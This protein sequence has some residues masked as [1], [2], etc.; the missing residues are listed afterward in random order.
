METLRMIC[1][2]TWA[3]F[4]E[5]VRRLSFLIVLAIT[6][7]AGYLFVPP[8]DAGYRVLQLGVYRGI[9]N[10]AW[11][12][13]MFGLIAALHLP[14]VGFF[15]VKNAVEH[16]RRTGVGEIIATSPISKL[17]YVA[18]KWLSNLAVLVLILSVMTVMA[19]AMQI[20][21]AEDTTLNLWALVAPI[22]MMGLPVLA[23]AAALAILFE[24][25]SFLRGSLG[26]V[27][28]FFLWLFA[29]A[30]V[31]SGAINDETGLAQRKNDLYGYTNQLVDIQGQ[32]LSIDP[33]AEVGSSLINVGRDVEHT[34]VWD[35]IQWQVTT[36]LERA[37]WAGLAVVLAL[38]A[39]IPFDRF[40]PAPVHVRRVSRPGFL[41]LAFVVALTLFIPDLPVFE[42]VCWINVALILFVVAFLPDRY[43]KA[44]RKLVGLKDK[45][46]LIAENG[47]QARQEE[48]SLTP[49]LMP[50]QN[51]AMNRLGEGVPSDVLT[52]ST[53]A[54]QNEG[55]LNRSSQIKPVEGMDIPAVISSILARLSVLPF[56]EKISA[57]RDAPAGRLYTIILAEC[58]LMLRGHHRIWWVGIVG[59]N[60]TC[61]VS[62]EE[63]VRRFLFPSLWAW[64]VFLWSQMGVRESRFNT[65]GMTFS[66]PRPVWRQL[67]AVWSA[68]VILT[69]ILGMGGWIRLL[70]TGEIIRLFAWFVGTL[71]VPSLALAMGVWTRHNRIF[72][73]IYL[74]LWYVGLI[75][76]V[77]IFDFIGITTESITRG[78]PWVYFGIAILLLGV[79]LAGRVRQLNI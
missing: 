50:F 14:L 24:S 73:F 38:A 70:L 32:V 56:L 55:Q 19:G 27:V 35:G 59:L 77:P 57:R 45:D 6:V 17:V 42:R 54:Y 48:S 65:E 43:M 25:V 74:L 75:E 20:I 76:Q 4:L 61:L 3:D 30:I 5:R 13:L 64:P 37:V 31:L 28:I 62:P 46:T 71:F 72:E 21:R 68:G 34:F 79:A 60:I 2:L 22:W 67:P 15:L 53:I 26:N 63:I 51:D 49:D 66:S 8:E 58:R 7:G 16:D 47:L 69:L 78:S 39:S 36:I 18:G 1:H 10:S 40:D 44:A 41:I 52:Q 11:I 9:Y 23:I 33:E 12:G 29:I